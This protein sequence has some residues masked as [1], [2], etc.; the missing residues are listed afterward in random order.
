MAG[1]RY[2]S[3]DYGVA[4]NA[5]PSQRARNH[6]RHLRRAVQ[7]R[8]HRHRRSTPRRTLPRPRRRRGRNERRAP[9]LPRMRTVR[10]RNDRCRC[11]RRRRWMMLMMTRIP[12]W[13][14]V[15]KEESWKWSNSTMFTILSKRVF[16]RRLPHVQRPQ[17]PPRIPTSSTKDARGSQKETTPTGCPKPTVTSARSW[18]KSLRRRRRIWICLAIRR[19]VRWAFGVFTARRVR[20]RR[21]GVGVIFIIRRR[22]GRCSRLFLTCRGGILDFVAKSQNIYA[23]HFDQ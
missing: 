11:R 19:L 15:V 9:I 20:R 14:M 5:Y 23:S 12:I 4:S 13:G 8:S 10:V 16:L 17:P 6:H 7:K 1:A 3:I 2:S 21:I 18:P 22:W